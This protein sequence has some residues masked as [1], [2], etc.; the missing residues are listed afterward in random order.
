MESYGYEPMIWPDEDRFEAPIERGQL[1]YLRAVRESSMTTGKGFRLLCGAILE[2]YGLPDQ[3]NAGSA[4]VLIDF[5]KRAP[6]RCKRAAE[7]QG[8]KDFL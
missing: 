5:F 3:I 1:K 4:E 8:W 2:G 7:R 6:A